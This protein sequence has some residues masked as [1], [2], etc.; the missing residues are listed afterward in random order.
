MTK[1]VA[2]KMAA[3]G[4][5]K[6]IMD[7]LSRQDEDLKQTKDIQ[8]N[9]ND[10][11]QLVLEILTGSS[12]HRTRGIRSTVE[13]LEVDF[14]VLKEDNDGFKKNVNDLRITVNSCDEKLQKIEESKRFTWSDIRTKMLGIFLGVNT[15]LAIGV[16]IKE[17]FFK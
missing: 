3:N 14:R 8:K 6:E 12:S 16:M 4:Q 2:A 5:I 15:L 13:T 9:T 7:R 10:K 1:R 17:L 11:V